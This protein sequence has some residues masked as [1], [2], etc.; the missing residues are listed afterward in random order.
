MDDGGQN[1]DATFYALIL[2]ELDRMFRVAYRLTEN[3]ADAEDLVHDVV[4]KLHA[5]KKE[6]S[7]ANN[8]SSW[9]SRIVYNQ[10]VDNWRSI[11][12]KRT[13]QEANERQ[14]MSFAMETDS[15]HDTFPDASVLAEVQQINGNVAGALSCL[16]KTYREIILLHDV[17]GYSLGELSYMTNTPQSTL[18]SRLHRGRAMLRGYLARYDYGEHH[19]D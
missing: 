10:F 5:R 12:R 14:A 16:K 8:L 17:E 11:K 4:L 19:V 2:P 1:L 3:H 15:C 6:V 9:V 7:L 18:K 13:M